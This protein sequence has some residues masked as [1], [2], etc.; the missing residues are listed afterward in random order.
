MSAGTILCMSG[1]KIFMDY[2]SILGPIDPQVPTP[3]TGDYVPALGYL[4][5]V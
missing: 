4:D 1:D 2:A 5:K 3:D